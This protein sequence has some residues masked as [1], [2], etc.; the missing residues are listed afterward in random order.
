MGRV[1]G[2]LIRVV[3]LY[4]GVPL[5]NVRAVMEAEVAQAKRNVK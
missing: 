2:G 4:P 1:E 5:E 3:G